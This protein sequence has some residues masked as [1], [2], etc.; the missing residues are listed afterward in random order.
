MSDQASPNSAQQQEPELDITIFF[1]RLGAGLPQIVGLALLGAVIAVASSYFV[2]RSSPLETKMRASF[3]FP[4]FERGQYPDESKFQA[5]DLRAPELTLQALLNL[6]IA[7]V[8]KIHGEIRGSLSI[9]GIIPPNIA[10]EREKLRASGQNIP[11]YI[12]DEYEITLSLPRNFPLTPKEREKFLNELLTLYRARFQRIYT[13]LPP[14][15]GTSFETLQ[16]TDYYEYELVLSQELQNLNDYLSKQL[17]KA[18]MFRSKTTGFSF[19]DLITQAQLFAQLRVNEVMGMIYSTGLTNNRP[20]ALTKIDYH[21]GLLNDEEKRLI[22]EEKVVKDLLLQAQ[23][24]AQSYVLT[25]RASA[26]TSRPFVDQNMMETLVANDAYNFLVKKALEAGIRVQQL[27]AR[28]DQVTARRQK[29]DSFVALSNV[30]YAETKRLLAKS[31]S[32]LEKDYRKLISNVRA[33]QQDYANQ[34]YADAIRPTL[35]PVTASY[36]VRLMVAAAAGSILGAALGSGLS[37]IGVYSGRRS[38]S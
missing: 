8:E 32:D 13:D 7:N 28:K 25:A 24:R 10:K 15:Y 33:T 27:R 30:D 36:L 2:I 31:M 19:N 29:I 37:L 1:R 20:L 12:A 14:L 4:G 9:I 22:D 34:E 21:L 17:N 16:T 11:P 23:S 35:E 5:D 3:S 38:G 6:K 26:D 18:K